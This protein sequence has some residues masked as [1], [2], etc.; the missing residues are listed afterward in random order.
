VPTN[1]GETKALSVQEILKI[2]FFT[3]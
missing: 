3:D 2:V 1:V